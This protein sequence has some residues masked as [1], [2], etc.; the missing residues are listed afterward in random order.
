[1]EV[2][3]PDVDSSKKA[4][5]SDKS[6]GWR[7][8]LFRAIKN[9][10]METLEYIANKEP[11]CVHDRFTTGMHEWELEWESPRWNE[12]REATMLFIACAYTQPLVVEW[13]MNANVDLKIKCGFG[14]SCWDVVGHFNDS[15]AKVQ[16]V[17]ALLGG[18]KRPMRPPCAPQV[19]AKMSYEETFSIAYEE[20]NAD[21]EQEGDSDEV[22]IKVPKRVSEVTAVCK[23]LVQWQCYWLSPGAICELRYRIDDDSEERGDWTIE[24]CNTWKKTIVGL[25]PGATYIFQVRGNPPGISGNVFRW[26]EWGEPTIQS[27]P[28]LKLPGMQ[29]ESELAEHGVRH[30]ESRGQERERDYLPREKQGNVAPP[31]SRAVGRYGVNSGEESK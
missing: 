14:Q 19:D 26:S 29:V 21:I 16:K 6:S 4:R 3:G 9:A 1:M 12:Y 30:S 15:E 11:T 22:R 24:R 31:P 13:L 28:A 2:A 27:M 7:V 23:V 10:N 20:K 17:K 8:V 18:A 5:N 25:R